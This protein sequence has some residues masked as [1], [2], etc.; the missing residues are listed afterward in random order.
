MKRNHFWPDRPRIRTI[1]NE[2]AIDWN[3]KHQPGQLVRFWTA[4]KDS[5]PPK[6]TARVQGRAFV[7]NG[8]AAVRLQ[9]I[10]GPFP[11]VRVEAIE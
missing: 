5:T 8:I 10:P 4:P 7:H 6:G 3:R 1:T 2:T 9:N 11:V